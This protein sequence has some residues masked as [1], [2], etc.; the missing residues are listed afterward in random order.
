MKN[1]FISLF[2]VFISLCNLNCW[3]LNL[4]Q[5]PPLLNPPPGLNSFGSINYVIDLPEDWYIS[6]IHALL[7]SG[8]FKK[9]LS[10]TLEG[11]RF[12]P[13][14]ID[15]N[16]LAFAIYDQI[17]NEFQAKIFLQKILTIRPDLKENLNEYIIKYGIKE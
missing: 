7:E 10:L 2:L 16:F 13:D 4:N 3:A 1:P 6:N 5:I 9:A 11:L 12:Y 15:L 8:K 14:S 17:N